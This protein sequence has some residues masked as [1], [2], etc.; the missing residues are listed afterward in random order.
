MVDYDLNHSLPN[1]VVY[2]K[3]QMNYH[4]INQ[5][6]AYHFKHEVCKIQFN[7]INKTHSII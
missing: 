5:I 1:I 6:E 4:T 7:L 3:K 2:K